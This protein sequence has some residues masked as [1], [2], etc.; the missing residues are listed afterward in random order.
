[1]NRNAERVGRVVGMAEFLQ[2]CA[3]CR[4]R[5]VARR[6]DALFCSPACRQADYRDRKR[7]EGDRRQVRGCRA[8]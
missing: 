5:F 6:R 1:M 3:R 8:Q 2:V 7:R 4:M